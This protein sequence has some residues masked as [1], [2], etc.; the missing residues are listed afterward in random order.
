MA[1]EDTEIL[2]GRISGV[3]GIKGWVRIYSYTRPRDGIFR[4]SPW[5][6]GQPGERQKY[7]V[8][9]SRAADK[10]LLCR[11]AGI[12]SRD[13]ARALIGMEVAIRR[14]QLPATAADEIYWADLQGLTVV[15]RDGTELG[16]VDYL[17]ETGANDVLVV[18]GNRKEHLIPYIRGQ[19]VVEID[20]ADGILR[21][22]WDEDF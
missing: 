19:T 22:D 13:Q 15:N 20:P 3:H 14:S 11:L 12:D 18:K 7:R 2:L 1:G 8:A 6:I 9:E 21:V 16:I 5:L 10:K 4:Y 17:I